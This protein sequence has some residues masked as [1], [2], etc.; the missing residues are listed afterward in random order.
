[1]CYQKMNRRKF[2]KGVGL[3]SA[4]IP[5]QIL[6]MDI[7]PEYST[8]IVLTDI[9]DDASIYILK[10]NETEPDFIGFVKDYK[11]QGYD[12]PILIRVRKAGYKPYEYQGDGIIKP[13]LIIDYFYENCLI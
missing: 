2:L 6:G 11:E 10:E 9:D 7:K 12:C 8:V 5:S 13:I 3:A 4:S 1:M